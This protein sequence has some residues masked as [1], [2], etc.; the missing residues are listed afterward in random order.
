MS[1]HSANNI[2][3][4]FP[5]I[6]KKENNQNL[7]KNI[8]YPYRF[9]SKHNVLTNS[10]FLI[11][12][13]KTG[14]LGIAM[15]WILRTFRLVKYKQINAE[16]FECSNLTI[17]NLMIVF[18]GPTHEKTLTKRLLILQFVCTILAFGI[19]YGLSQIFY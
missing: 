18:F 17:I 4:P 1:L 6:P 8:F 7:S 12:R 19:R 15:I 5:S 11:H 9:D 2:H 3:F 16:T 10:T 13:K 14:T